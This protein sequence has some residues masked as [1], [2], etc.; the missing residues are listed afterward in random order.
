MKNFLIF[1]LFYDDMNR[2]LI[3]HKLVSSHR[4]QIKIQNQKEFKE[5]FVIPL[6]QTSKSFLAPHKETVQVE[7][8][9][10]SNI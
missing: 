10:L 8:Q 3:S 9:S 5:F 1:F 2:Y 4:K 6:N 7:Y